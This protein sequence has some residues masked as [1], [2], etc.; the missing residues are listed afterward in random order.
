[1]KPSNGRY[2][3]THSNMNHNNEPYNHHDLQGINTIRNV[4]FV[5]QLSLTS[6]STVTDSSIVCPVE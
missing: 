6:M 1:M 5:V 4:A 3:P 2:M